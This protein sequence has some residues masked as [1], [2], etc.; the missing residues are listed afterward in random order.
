MI[1]KFQTSLW[2]LGAGISS[3]SVGTII[4]MSPT[5]GVEVSTFTWAIIA[6]IALVGGMLASLFSLVNGVIL[7]RRNLKR[8]NH[9]LR[10]IKLAMGEVKSNTKTRLKAKT[11]RYFNRIFKVCVTLAVA[12]LSVILAEQYFGLSLPNWVGEWCSRVV[13]AT[14]FGGVVAKLTSEKDGDDDIG[15]QLEKLQSIKK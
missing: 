2:Q 12:S 9:N 11:P 7:F 8:Y 10:K 3:T 13:A 6:K 15:K 1:D 5:V 4:S 14:I